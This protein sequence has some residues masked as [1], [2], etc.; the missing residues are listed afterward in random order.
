MR[1][2]SSV[3]SLLAHHFGTSVP[4]HVEEGADYPVL[5]TDNHDGLSGHSGC[6]EIP[7]IRDLTFVTHEHPNF[8]K[9]VALLL[10]KDFC[11]SENAIVEVVGAWKI[12]F[13]VS[14][15]RHLPRLARVRSFHR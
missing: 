6:A 11:V 5:S 7:R 9:Y 14:I 3:S 15:P 1:E 2:G 8:L 12:G 4:A 10:T 13:I